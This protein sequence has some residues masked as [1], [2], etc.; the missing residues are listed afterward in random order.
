MRAKQIAVR[1][2]WTFNAERKI[3][4]KAD[5]EYVEH[6]RELLRQAVRRRLRTDSP[7]LAELSGGFDSSSIVC[8]A[9]NILKNHVGAAPVDTLS[10]HDSNEPEEDDLAYFMRVEEVRK[11]TGFHVDLRGSGDSFL[12]DRTA[13][14]AIPTPGSRAEV[15]SALRP[16]LKDGGYRVILSGLGGDQMNGQ[17]LDPRI[18]L[19]DLILELRLVEFA[20]QLMAWSLLI[21]KRPLIQLFFQT[22]VRLVPV[23]IRAQFLNH[24][25]R[26]PWVD[27]RFARK[28]GMSARLLE[29]VEGKWLTRPS[30]MDAMQTI[31]TLSRQLSDTSPSVI[32]KRYPYL[33]QDF[34]EFITAIPL[35]QVLRPGQRRLLMRKAMADILPFEVLNR[36]NKARVGRYPCIALE[37]HWD[38]VARIFSSPEGAR[39]GY[40]NGD[41][42]REAL[43]AM[44]NGRPP[45]YILRLVNAVF[46]ELWLRDAKDRGVISLET[47]SIHA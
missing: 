12:F 20:R 18:Q 14:M 27:R 15:T 44:K 36:R 37:K 10:F 39:L 8:M 19:A 32:E 40:L 43:L 7:V 35:D 11:R 28:H 2:Y 1:A 45:T 33:D 24:C 25:E 42:I 46:L 47:V 16:I 17:S 4:Y 13:F 23:Q 5:G 9:D 26:V 29:I 21:R 22:L 34:V 41:Q 31:A 38:Q 3:R 6:Y 30:T